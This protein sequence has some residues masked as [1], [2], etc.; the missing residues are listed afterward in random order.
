ML[1]EF[2]VSKGGRGLGEWNQVLHIGGKEMSFTLWFLLSVLVF[3]FKS[4]KLGL[5]MM[6][7][8]PVLAHANGLI[9]GIALV[10]VAIAWTKF[11]VFLPFRIIR[12]FW[13]QGN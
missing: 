3:L 5:V 9:L 1:S 4:K 11:V 13:R 7:G 6:I 8:I 12:G 2:P 10:A